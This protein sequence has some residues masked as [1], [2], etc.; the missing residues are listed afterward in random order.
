MKF[1]LVLFTVVL[2]TLSGCSHTG[3]KQN[4]TLDNARKT[5]LLYNKFID[6]ESPNIAQ[7]NLFITRMPKGGD[8]HHHYSGSIYAE[9]YLDWAESGDYRIDKN[10]FKIVKAAD[11]RDNTCCLSV[12]QLRSDPESY[13]KL[14]TLWSDKDYKNHYHQQLPPDA[15]FFK[16]FGYFGPVSKNFRE[17]LII[18]REQAIKENVS[19]IETMLSSVDYSY[20][21]QPFDEDARKPAS[22]ETLIRLFDKFSAKIK[23][24]D[25]L[26]KK[27]NALS[28]TIEAAHKGIDD[29]RFVMRYQTYASRNGTPSAV[30]SALYAA[31]LADE[32]INLLVG[33]NFLGPENGLVALADYNLHM[34]MFNYLRKKF[35]KVNVALHAGELTLGMVPPKDLTHHIYQAVFLVGAQRIGHGVDLPYEEKAIELLQRIK[36]KSAVE[37]NLTSNEFILGV[38]GREHPYL[39]YSAYDIPLVICTDDSGVS[40]NNLSNEYVLLAARYKPDYK[41]VKKYV[42][43]SIKYSFLP[44]S[45]KKILTKAL[46]SRF[47]KFEAETAQYA[48][49][50]SK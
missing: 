16:T 50:V 40:R 45:D 8:L 46:D 21:D 42:Y 33:V 28:E 20:P 10:T 25:R 6:G 9:T 13:I 29:D 23:A 4:F 19:Y 30:F 14:M 5:E 11:I 31:F 41:T 38:K 32:K 27:I 24:D 17:G 12:K 44:E 15:N 35:P 36:E 26:M 48:D 39:I 2:F 37:I 22:P 1:K 3:L 18:L 47:E 7:L 49:L 43:N 34:Q